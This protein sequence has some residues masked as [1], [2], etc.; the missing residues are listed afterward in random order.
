MSV[1]F[2]E[3]NNVNAG[4]SA[5]ARGTLNSMLMKQGYDDGLAP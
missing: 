1:G 4:I 2:G 5:V 3:Q